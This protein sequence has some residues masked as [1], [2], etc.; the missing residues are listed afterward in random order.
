MNDRELRELARGTYKKV[1]IGRPHMPHP[2]SDE[3]RRKIDRLYDIL[4]RADAKTPTMQAAEEAAARVAGW[5]DA[6]REAAERIVN[7]GS[8][9]GD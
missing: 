2:D 6:K 5:S 8:Y 7:S 4:C 9:K 3:G 1:C